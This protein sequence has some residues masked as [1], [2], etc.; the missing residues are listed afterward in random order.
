MKQ[1][2]KDI[3]FSFN[4]QF[5]GTVPYMYLD[6]LGKVTV[7]VGN[8]IDPISLCLNLPFLHKSDSSIA[9][10]NDII[11]EWRTV[12]LNTQLAKQGHL[13]ASKIT[14]LFLTAAAISNL[15]TSKSIEFETYLKT[16]A[17][18]NFDQYPAD[19]QLA[20]MSMAWACGEGLGSIFIN[21]KKSCLNQ[22]WNTAADQC[23]IR[24][25]NNAGLIPRNKANRKLL[26][27]AA[28]AKYSNL[29]LEQ[30]YGL[31]SK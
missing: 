28:Y 26:L 20:I 22:D 9:S 11:M 13:A 7:G 18:T 21:F 30:I 8:L 6:I 31:Q 25:T 16:H 1:S 19:A 14:K 27:S 23:N 12:K 2:V 15:V 29:D 24:T 5:E 4:Q 17:F 10:K 3:F